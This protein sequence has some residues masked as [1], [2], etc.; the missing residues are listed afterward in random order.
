MLFSSPDNMLRILSC[1]TM[2]K[3]Y[4][5]VEH[6][7]KKEYLQLNMAISPLLLENDI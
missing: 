3:D 1:N 2:L 6:S 5:R 4:N 7:Q